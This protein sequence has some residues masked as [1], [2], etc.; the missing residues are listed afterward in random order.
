MVYHVSNRFLKKNWSL[1]IFT[2]L[3]V[4]APSWQHLGCQFLHQLGLVKLYYW[5]IDLNQDSKVIQG[6]KWEKL[7]KTM[8]ILMF[9]VNFQLNQIQNWAIPEK[10]QTEGV[11]NILFSTPPPGI[12]YFFTLPLEVPSKTKLNP[13]V[14]IFSGTANCFIQIKKMKDR[15]FS[16]WC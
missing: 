11:E 2:F 3:W 1:G 9:F 8:K 7:Y 12:L 10:I 4:L 14:W 16:R 15:T 6:V 13:P 5:L